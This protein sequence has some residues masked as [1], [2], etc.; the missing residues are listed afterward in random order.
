MDWGA[1][2]KDPSTSFWCSD[3]FPEWQNG[4]ITGKRTVIF[5]PGKAVTVDWQHYA[6]ARAKSVV[7]Y[8]LKNVDFF[9]NKSIFFFISSFFISCSLAI[10]FSLLF[11]FKKLIISAGI[12]A[13]VE[14]SL[15]TTRPVFRKIRCALRF[16]CL[17][18]RRSS[19]YQDACGRLESYPSLYCIDSLILLNSVSWNHRDHWLLEQ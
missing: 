14:T 5:L 6:D 4:C 19:S 11:F 1:S 2:V 7:D 10:F 18:K 16:M 17:A 12:Y 3:E 8:R 13:S 9:K 15:W